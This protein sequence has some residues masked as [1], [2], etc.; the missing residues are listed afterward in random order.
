MFLLLLL[1]L[2]SLLLLDSFPRA[3][4]CYEGRAPCPWAAGFP[5]IHHPSAAPLPLASPPPRAACT[6]TFGAIVQPT[7]QFYFPSPYLG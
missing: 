5:S 6:F 3:T 7:Q 2:L 4:I 1:L